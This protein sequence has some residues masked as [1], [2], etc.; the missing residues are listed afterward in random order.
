MT[1]VTLLHN[2]R[3]SKSRQALALLEAAGATVEVRRYLDAP[4]DR[5][6]LEAL[7]VKLGGSALSWTRVK[8]SAFK[9]AGLT[10]E[11]SDAAL[12]DAMATHPILMERPVVIVGERAVVGRP[13]ERVHDLL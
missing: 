9:E 6:E 5:T 4:L 3:C 10:R 7:A 1:S 12:L 8:E 13:P 2:P 11:S